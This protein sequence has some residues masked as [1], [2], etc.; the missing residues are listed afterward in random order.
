MNT[1]QTLQRLFNSAGIKYFSAREVLFLGAS[2][3]RL[4]L[5]TLPPDR[6]LPNIMPTVRVADEA[7][8]RLGK[9][10]MVASGYRNVAYNRA[11]GGGRASQHLLFTALD[12]RTG[13]V[14]SLYQILLDL[15]RE[16][17]AGVSGGL[18]LYRS[19]VHVDCRPYPA[20]WRG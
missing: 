19:F 15:R 3:T 6:M 12:L 8:R 18:G 11:V 1:E 16:R 10:I 20:T 4:N 5:N 9:P 17:F 2:N 13:P 14:A 7:R